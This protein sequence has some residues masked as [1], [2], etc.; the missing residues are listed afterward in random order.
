MFPFNADLTAQIL[1]LNV[2][3]SHFG[4]EVFGFYGYRGEEIGER[5][6]FR[7]SHTTFH[8]G[9]VNTEQRTVTFSADNGEA[10]GVYTTFV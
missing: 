3:G 8:H 4:S 9:R 5:S 7:R 6:F 10:F 2:N 1:L